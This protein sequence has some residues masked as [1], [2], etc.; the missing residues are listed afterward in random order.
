MPKMHGIDISHY[1]TGLKLTNTDAEFAIMKA[2]EGTTYVDQTCDGFVNQAKNAGI[3]WGVYHFAQGGGAAEADHFLTNVEGYI[4]EGL[5]VLDWETHVSNVTA[6]KAWLDHVYSKTGIRAVIYMSQSV[7]TSYDWSPVAKN[8]ALWVARYNTHIGSTGAWSGASL[9]Q[10]TDKHPTGGMNVD[11]DWF[12][13]TRDAWDAIATGG[14]NSGGTKPDP[15]PDPKPTELTVDGKWGTATTKALQELL[16]TPV[17][18][19]VSGQPNAY[20]ASNP[21]LLSGWQW[22]SNPS[23]SP[24]IAALQ[25]KL[26]TNDDGRIG[27]ATIKAL[28]SKLG[29]GVDGKVSNPS[30]MV[31]QLQKNLNAGKL[32]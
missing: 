20:K 8:H 26:G 12:Y 14:K 1:Q 30:P 28:Q 10:Y 9:W 3:P 7:A 25:R 13:G 22:T 29:T 24:M 19:K 21:G 2:T 5:L 11:A 31:R 6:A 15:K 17:D 32:W 23:S 4:G 18:G 27:P 16:G